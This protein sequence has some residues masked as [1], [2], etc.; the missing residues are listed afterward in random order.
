M[1]EVTRG[2]RLMT[3]NFFVSSVVKKF[4]GG[5]ALTSIE[6]VLHITGNLS[7]IQ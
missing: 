5:S 4:G 1:G 6:N 3:N 7:L 2:S